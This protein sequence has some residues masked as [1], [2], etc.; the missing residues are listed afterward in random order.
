M[1]TF[2]T[3]RDIVDMYA[4]GVRQLEVDDQVV[5]TDLARDKAQE[6]GLA[7][8]AAG[9]SKGQAH[10]P[11]PTAAPAPKPGL[12][13]AELITR[14]KSGVIAKLGTE[15]YNDLL[16]QVIPQVLARL[17]LSSPPP[18]GQKKEAASGRNY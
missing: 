14:V 3:E 8:V 17:D 11:A 18:P 7:L 13:Q 1:K 4:A 15:A 9:Q 12:S 6:L 2:Y 16:D 5:L 10:P